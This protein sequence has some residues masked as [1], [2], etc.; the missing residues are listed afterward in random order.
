MSSL[1][2][3]ATTFHQKKKEAV[4]SSRPRISLFNST[5][6]ELCT[7]SI[8]FFVFILK[9]KKSSSKLLPF[10]AHKPSILSYIKSHIKPSFNSEHNPITLSS[11]ILNPRSTNSFNSKPMIPIISTWTNPPFFPMSQLGG[12]LSCIV[13][14]IHIINV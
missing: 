2:A 1:A 5:K 14:L 8:V 7:M 12:K 11:T 10:K 3:M 13:N 6:W 4:T 9:P